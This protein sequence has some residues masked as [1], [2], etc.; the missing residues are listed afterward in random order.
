MV[1]PLT[2]FRLHLTTPSE[3]LDIAAVTDIGPVRKENQ[4][5]WVAVP[6]PGECGC[7]L[8]VADGMGSMAG[9]GTAA[10]VAVEALVT[11]F[12]DANCVLD[13]D[14][15]RQAFVQANRAVARANAEGLEGGTT[16]VAAI[17]AGSALTVGNIGDSRAYLIRVGAA[18]RL[19][20]DHSWVEEEMRAG[21]ITASQA[22]GHPR[23]NVLTR[24]LMD[25]PVDADI[26]HNQLQVGDIVMLCSDGV[27]DPLGDDAIGELFSRNDH[28]H[29]LVA[30][31]CQA[32]INSGGMDNVTIVAARVSDA[33]S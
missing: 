7:L 3:I 17:V 13:D 32:A 15:L 16:L 5:A 19:T 2:P 1:D 22:V 12:A 18:R 27:W 33:L 14:S 8:T 24:A 28:M 26:V 9:S 11:H 20:A 6:L 23:R 31:A 29:M 10:R 30:G 4:D 25:E 21:H